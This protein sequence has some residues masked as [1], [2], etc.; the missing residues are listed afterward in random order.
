VNSRSG[1]NSTWTARWDVIATHDEST[2]LT[3]TVEEVGTA[4]GISRSR[5][6]EAVRKGEISGGSN[7]KPALHPKAALNRL[8]ESANLPRSRSTTISVVKAAASAEC[9]AVALSGKREWRLA[10]EW[11]GID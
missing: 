9:I 2:T 7:R 10:V 1:E 6:Y 5:T 11:G 3:S 8:L 4:P